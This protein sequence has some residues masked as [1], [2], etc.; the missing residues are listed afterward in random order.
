MLYIDTDTSGHAACVC[1]RVQGCTA[2]TPLCFAG[3]TRSGKE[4]RWL[5]VTVLICVTT[6]FSTVRVC[7]CVC[8]QVVV[9]AISKD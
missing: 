8:P 6:F 2:L 1:E 5:S 3:V 9:M 4:V 7:V